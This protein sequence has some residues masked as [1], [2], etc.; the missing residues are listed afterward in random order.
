MSYYDEEIELAIE[1]ISEFGTEA[2]VFA[3]G[4]TEPTAVNAYAVMI[5]TSTGDSSTV[6]DTFGTMDDDSQ[7]TSKTRILVAYPVMPIID[8]NY[9]IRVGSQDYQVKTFTLIKPDFTSKIYHDCL[10]FET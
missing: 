2:K 9:I 8:E 4:G 6:A 7:T 10:C 1:L 5:P 3:L